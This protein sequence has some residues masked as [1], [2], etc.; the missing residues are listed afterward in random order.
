MNLTRLV[1]LGLLAEHGP[2]HGHQLRRDIEVTQADQWA[3]IGTGPLHRELREL[4]RAGFIEPIRV[5]QVGR[6]PQRTIYQITAEGRAALDALRDQAIARYVA[7][8]DPIAVALI[9][10][11]PITDQTTFAALLARHRASVVSE[12]NRLSLEH[13]RGLAEGFLD[14]ANSPSQAAAF[15]RT[16]LHAAAE[17]QWH[18]ECDELFGQQSTEREEPPSDRQQ[19][20]LP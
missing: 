18:T 12:L 6:R 2:R 16:E 20:V 10:A 13:D 11:A 4:E 8:S 17:L 15:R 7:P 9:F 5:E 14:P 3:G 1:V 19:G